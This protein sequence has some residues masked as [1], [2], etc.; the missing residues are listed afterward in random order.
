MK[1]RADAIL[2]PAQADYLERLLPPRDPLLREMEA[3]AAANH[4]PISDPEVGQ[5]LAIL[6]RG[7]G[8]RRRGASERPEVR[9][10]VG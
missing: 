9:V 6:A 1:D 2:R 4:V 3:F 8:A 10:A 5:M 7:C